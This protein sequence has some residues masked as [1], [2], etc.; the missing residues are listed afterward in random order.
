MKLDNDAAKRALTLA[1]RGLDFADCGE[2][3]G[4]RTLTVEDDRKDYGETRFQTIGS[5][6]DRTVMIVWTVRGRSRRVISMRECNARERQRYKEA[7]DR[8][9]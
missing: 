2:V 9:G 8:P 4:G 3:F 5:L 6:G 1:E 7:L